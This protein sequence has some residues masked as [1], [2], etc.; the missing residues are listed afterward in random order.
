MIRRPPRSTLFPYTTLFRSMLPG[1]NSSPERRTRRSLA[2][3]AATDPRLAHNSW[4]AV[5]NWCC[6]RSGRE[7]MRQTNDLCEEKFCHEHRAAA[8]SAK[9][10]LE[11]ELPTSAGSRTP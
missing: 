1:K 2:P 8:V 9:Q 7:G 11:I 10:W 3:E 6:G 4:Q 5:L